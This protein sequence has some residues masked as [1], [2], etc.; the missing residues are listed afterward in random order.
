MEV[1]SGAGA[2]L[3]TWAQSFETPHVAIDNAT[4]SVQGPVGVWDRVSHAV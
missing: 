4:E 1:F 3:E 2:H